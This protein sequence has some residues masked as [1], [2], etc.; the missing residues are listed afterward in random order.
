MN[1]N[2]KFISNID[3]IKCISTDGNMYS[4]EKWRLVTNIENNIPN[5]MYM[6][7]N[8]GRVLRIYDE[9]LINPVETKN[10]YLRVPMKRIGLNSSRYNLI[11]RM[12]LLEFEPTLNH[13]NLQVNHIDGNKKNNNLNNLEWVTPSQN[14]IHAYTNNLKYCKN[15]PESPNT[16]ITESQIIQMVDLLEKRYPKKEIS[17]ITN[18]SIDTI[19]RMIGGFE[20]TNIH[21]KYKL[22]RFKR[23]ERPGYTDEDLHK[24][25]K[26]IE[27]NRS[28]YNTNAELFK[29]MLNDLFG[30]Q[31]VRSDSASLSRII[32]KKT[33][34]DITSKY[35]F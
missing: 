19:W 11:H 20:W 30:K 17:E 1:S 33:R 28:K 25:C 34:I 3:Y 22:Y 8:Y 27:T 12:E 21:N 23:K 6:V 26:Y 18:I 7:S 2:I 31:Y 24:I 13:R 16:K 5:N 14:I 10:G 4:D 15:G 9:Y 35:N 29:H 32:N